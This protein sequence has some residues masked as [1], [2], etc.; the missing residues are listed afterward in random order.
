VPMQES[1]SCLRVCSG[2]FSW[3]LSSGC[4]PL[5]YISGCL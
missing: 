3:C 2:Q 1:H 4:H 5:V